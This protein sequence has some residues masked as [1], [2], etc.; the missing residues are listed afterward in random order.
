MI[1]L[2][3]ASLIGKDVEIHDPETG[4]SLCR[5]SDLIEEMG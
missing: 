1:K 3:Q 2:G 4:F 5:N